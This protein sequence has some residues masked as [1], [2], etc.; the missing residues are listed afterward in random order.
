[1]EL[2]QLKYFVMV[3]KTLS[4]SEASRKLFI[5]QGTLSQQI[6]QLE[7]E[8]GALLFARTSHSV[9][10][11]EAGEELLPL[12]VDTIEASVI[13]RN[14]MNDLKKVLSGTLNI[15]VTHSFSAL[16]A[17]TVKNFLK[18]YPGV[19]LNIFYKTAS[20]LIDMLRNKQVDLILAFKPI[21]EHGDI[22][23]E[24]LFRSHLSVVMRK[25]HP[26]S[27][28]KTLSLEEIEKQGI[29]LPASGLQARKIFENFV[30]LDTRKLDVRV[31]LNDPNMI[32]D[33]VQGTNLIALVSSLASYY[34]TNLIAVP[35]EEGG[36][37]MLGCVQRL[38][39]GYRK[40]SAEVF[41][42]M[43]RDA[44]QIERLCR[45]MPTKG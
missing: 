2:R 27:D 7:D 8:L 5:T 13:C 15:G 43:L 31:E 9:I 37:E 6:K 4:F 34:R 3:A 26:L 19:K 39:E 36:H 38:K 25:G 20:E 18:A 40:R 35:L 14:K 10:L 1:M 32:M 16:V 17:D 45:E 28:R 44:A 29:V 11:T 23:S 21:M 22:E 42:D 12:A 41:L 30:G 33:I 24:V